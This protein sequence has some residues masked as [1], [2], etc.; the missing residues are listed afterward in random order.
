MSRVPEKFADLLSRSKKALGY[1]GLVKKNGA[2]QVTP[3]WFDFD[4]TYL[5]VNTAR[6]R[7]KDKI[8]HRHPSVALTIQDPDDHY[9]YL[10]VSGKVVEE[11]EVGAFDVIRDLNFKYHGDRDYSTSPG[12]VRVTYKI[13]PEQFD[14]HG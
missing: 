6:G 5:V 13:L 7:V 12:E 8:M 1:L 10:Q 4:G 9:R 3:V 14:T 2:P 11:T